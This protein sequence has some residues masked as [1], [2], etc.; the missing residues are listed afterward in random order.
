MNYFPLHILVKDLSFMIIY[1][2]IMKYNLT[3]ETFLPETISNFP[4]A[5][6]V[7]FLDM[8]SASLFYNIIPLLFSMISYFFIFFIISKM[9]LKK[10]NLSVNVI[11][12]VLTCTTPILYLIFN[13]WKHNDYYQTRA[14]IISWFLCFL[15][16]MTMYYLLNYK[17]N[18]RQPCKTVV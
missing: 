3:N 5:T 14:E 2:I 18:K 4:G 7:T 1:F 17:S 11:G 10:S 16:S 8:I 9:F 6:S 15:I 13:G 12:F